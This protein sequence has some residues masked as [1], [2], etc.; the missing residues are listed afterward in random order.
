MNLKLQKIR[1]W[2]LIV[3]SAIATSILATSIPSDAATLAFSQVDVEFTNFSESLATIDLVNQ[4]SISGETNG[5]LFGGQNNATNQ[6]TDAPPEVNSS[7]F[8]LAFGDSRN[9][10]GSAQTQ[11]GIL[12]NFDVDAG[13]L[14]SFDFNTI[15]SLTTEIDNPV[16]EEANANGNI[17]FF[18]LDTTNI[19][20]TDIQDLFSNFISN[21]SNNNISFKYNV[22][23]AFKLAGNLNTGGF[24]DFI[25]FQ[26]SQNIVFTSETKQADFGGNQESASV[27]IQGS[28]QR[29][30][31]NKSNVTLLAIRRSKAQVKV[32]ES[33]FIVA[34]I[35]LLL[36]IAVGGFPRRRTRE[37]NQ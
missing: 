33:S 35:F 5:G 14:F 1:Q 27:L 4:A 12:G 7:A 23:D 25:D 34:F 32:P 16:V 18:L 20:L 9:Y 11:A 28:L 30:F 13:E 10:T 6:F 8:S 29:S 26:H 2:L 31:I 36:I 3:P 22:L 37:F 21:I 15:V 17:S 24:E 19:P